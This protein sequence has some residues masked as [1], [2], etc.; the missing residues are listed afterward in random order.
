MGQLPKPKP[1]NNSIVQLKPFPKAVAELD[2][3]CDEF[4]QAVRSGDVRFD[5]EDKSFA[6]WLERVSPDL[7]SWLYDELA[8]MREEFQPPDAEHSQGGANGESWRAILQCPTF[9]ALSREAKLAL[10]DGIELREFAAGET[11]IRSGQSAAGLFLITGGR[12][13]IVSDQESGR[14]KIDSDGSGSV[15]GEM[16]TLTGYPCTADVIAETTVRALVLPI[17][18]FESLRQQHPEVEIALSQLVSDRLGHRRKDALCGKTIG[19]YLLEECL[20]IGAMGVVYKAISKSGDSVALKM[21]RHRFIYSPSAV[22]RFDQEAEIVSR[23]EHP[24]IVG[25]RD[26]FVAYRTRFIVLELFDGADLRQVV[27]HHGALEESHAK[28]VL[29]QI[30][31]GLMFAHQRGV[32]HLDLKPANLL[33]NGEGRIAITDFG[34]SRLIESDGGDRTL[35]G[36]PEYMPPEQFMMS[37][38]GPHCDYY[39]LA[40]V[41]YELLT[42]A[43]LVE[44]DRTS[45][46]FYR[47][48]HPRELAWTAE[49]G[50]E[51]F[52]EVWNAALH[53]DPSLRRLDLSTLAS[54]AH[55][56]PELAQGLKL[57][58]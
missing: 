13:N 39:S 33:L 46:L 4:E 34:L 18:A 21:L 50:S 44:F 43:R 48:P 3:V 9:R 26:H 10:A 5:E 53:P 58:D 1:K 31:R 42:G 17:A 23:L 12:V 25:V 54:W 55:P 19:G 16:S 37:N 45:N 11:L 6:P 30:A 52:R 56:V 35:V 47:S 28:R 7:R 22:S 8:A 2:A 29:G 41:A 27:R 38:L 20:G 40:C 14:Y 57:G 15:L 24:H 32:L 49:V 36:T 51:S